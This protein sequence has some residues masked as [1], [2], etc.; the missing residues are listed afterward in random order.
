MHTP[1]IVCFG[2]KIQ[3]SKQ[4]TT[5]STLAL[6]TTLL[7]VLG[8]RYKFQS[9]SQRKRLI[10]SASPDCLFWAQDTNFKAI[11]NTGLIATSK[12]VLFVLGS[13]YKFQ[14]NSQP[15]TSQCIR[16]Y[17]CLFWAQDTN[18][19]AI[20]NRQRPRASLNRIVCFGLKI[21][22]SKQFTTMRKERELNG[23]LFVLGS[24]YKFQS[25]SQ[26]ERHES[27]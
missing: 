23:Q 13:R 22:I 27:N 21:Q 11:H 6:R 20:H 2:L 19:K 14:S 15:T 18:F 12:L 3:I 1:Q 17:Y 24:R 9:N 16:L 8:S 10:S 25:N 7:F 4:F 5:I 26:H